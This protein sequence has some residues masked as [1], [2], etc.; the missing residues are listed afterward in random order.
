MASDNFSVLVKAELDP[1]S[2]SNLK[3][4]LTNALKKNPIPLQFE[5]DGLAV[6]VK[7]ET[8]KA[9]KDAKV[10][11][12][13]DTTGFM[14]EIKQDVAAIR[15]VFDNKKLS[16]KAD[17]KGIT[18]AKKEVL[19]LF[20]DVSKIESGKKL[21][22]L[23][24][25]VEDWDDKF[26]EVKENVK[27]LR[28]FVNDPIDVKVRL[29]TERFDTEVAE[30]KNKLNS[31]LTINVDGANTTVKIL[32]DMNIAANNVKATASGIGMVF[33]GVESEVKET[34][35]EV[36]NLNRAVD[37]IGKSGGIKSTNLGRISDHISAT[38]PGYTVLSG[39]GKTSAKSVAN[40]IPVS[41][42]PTFDQDDL[43][44]AVLRQNAEYASKHLADGDPF[45]RSPN[46]NHFFFKMA[47]GSQEGFTHPNSQTD[48]DGVSYGRL[49]DPTLEQK[50]Y[51][52]RHNG[53]TLED[54]FRQGKHLDKKELQR[55]AE[56]GGFQTLRIDYTPEFDGKGKFIR[57]K[58]PEEARGNYR[59]SERVTSRFVSNDEKID[60]AR[61][62]L[63]QKREAYNKGG[64]KTGRGKSHR[65][66]IEEAQRTL[67]DAVRWDDKTGGFV[68]NE[69]EWKAMRDSADKA[70]KDKMTKAWKTLTE[71]SHAEAL[72]QYRSAVLNTKSLINQPGRTPLQFER[73]AVHGDNATASG[74]SFYTQLQD[75]IAEETRRRSFGQLAERA[76]KSW[77][78]YTGGDKKADRDKSARAKFK[79][80]ESELG[81]LVRWDENVVRQITHDD[82]RVETLNGG[83]VIDEARYEEEE[84][85]RSGAD[86][87]R[88]TRARRTVEDVDLQNTR[89]RWERDE[90]KLSEAKKKFEADAVRYLNEEGIGAGKVKHRV[91]S[92]WTNAFYSQMVN[93]N[94]NTRGDSRRVSGTGIGGSYLPPGYWSQPDFA[95][96]YLTTTLEGNLRRDVNRDNRRIKQSQNR[97]AALQH[98][99]ENGINESGFIAPGMSEL[100]QFGL[101]EDDYAAFARGRVYGEG[102]ERDPQAVLRNI[103]SMIA[104]ENEKLYGR[105][106]TED[107]KSQ[108]ATAKQ[109]VKTLSEELR[110]ENIQ[111]LTPAQIEMK[112]QRYKAAQDVVTELEGRKVKG[113]I[114]EREERRSVANAE[115]ARM[116]AKFGIEGLDASI[117]WE[118]D[119]PIRGNADNIGLSPV[120]LQGI[121]M[122]DEDR[123]KVGSDIVQGIEYG[124]NYLGTE[125]PASR[126]SEEESRKL[127]AQVNAGEKARVL[128]NANSQLDVAQQNI[129][130]FRE[131]SLQSLDEFRIASSDIDDEVRRRAGLDELEAQRAEMQELRH[132]NREIRD[133][134]LS[135][136]DVKLNAN[137][138]I[139][140]SLTPEEGKEFNPENYPAYQEALQERDRLMAERQ[141]IEADYRKGDEYSAQQLKLNEA[142]QKGAVIIAQHELGRDIQSG[143]IDNAG[144]ERFVQEAREFESLSKALDVAR[145][146]VGQAW[147]EHQATLAEQKAVENRSYYDDHHVQYFADETRSRLASE[148]QSAFDQGFIDEG[149][150]NELNERLN[151]AYK[152]FE[153]KEAEIQVT[154]DTSQADAKL[155]ATEDKAEALDNKEVDI[156]VE[157]K[158]EVESG[159]KTEATSKPDGDAET[160]VKKTDARIDNALGKLGDAARFDEETGKYVIDKDKLKALQEGKSRGEKGAL[161]R[162]A[163]MVDPD[164]SWDEKK[165]KA[166]SKPDTSSTEQSTKAL[167]ENAEAS[168]KAAEAQEQGTKITEQSTTA[169][170]QNTKTTQENNETRENKLEPESKPKDKDG[171]K[172]SDT[173]KEPESKPTGKTKSKSKESDKPVELSDTAKDLIEQQKKINDI[174][175]QMTDRSL[176]TED[177][178]RLKSEL[179]ELTTGFNNA[180]SAANLTDDEMNAV[181]AAF[182][183]AQ[184]PVKQ[185]TDSFKKFL[186][187]AKK[188]GNYDLKGMKLDTEDDIKRAEQDINSL[189]QEYD[190]LRQSLNGQLSGNQLSQVVKEMDKVRAKI[191][192]INRAIDDA[193]N[194][195]VDVDVDKDV[196]VYKDKDRDKDF[197]VDKHEAGTVRKQVVD[198]IYQAQGR[199]DDI[200]WQM[201]NKNLDIEGF[202]K[203]S[204]ELHDAEVAYNE[205]IRVSGVTEAEMKE[206]AAAFKAVQAPTEQTTASF[207]KLVKVAKRIEDIKAIELDGEIVEP[208]Q[209]NKAKQELEELEHQYEQLRQSLRGQLSG[210]QLDALINEFDDTGKRV[211]K[212]RTINDNYES[213]KYEADYIVQ[214]S[215]AE[216]LRGKNVALDM[217]YDELKKTYQEFLAIMRSDEATI[218]EK[219]AAEER[220][221]KALKETGNAYRA[222]QALIKRDKS[223]QEI[224]KTYRAMEKVK[225]EAEVLKL[226]MAAWLRSNSAAVEDYGHKI[227]ELQ[228]RLK[229][230]GDAADLSNIR[231]EFKKV[232]LE[233]ELAGKA[234]AT[235][236]DRLKQQFTKYAA[237]FSVAELAMEAVQGLRYMYQAVLEVDTAMVGLRRVTDMTSQEY[238]QMFDNM[239][240]SSKEYGQTLTDTING[241]ADWVRAGFDTGTSLKLAEQTSVYQH[242]SDLDY[243]T[244]V[245]NQLTAYKGFESQLSDPSVFGKDVAGAVTYI[246]D[247]YNEIDNQFAVTSAGIGE[248]IQ[249][250]A[251]S[252][253]VAGNSLE[254]TVALVSAAM[255]TTQDPEGAGSSMKILSMRLRGM[256]GD[257]EALGEEVDDNVENI[258]KMQGQ[259]LNLTHG[260]VNIFDDAGEFRSTYD[261]MK[262]ISEVWDDLNSIEQADL[263]ET[264]AGK[265][266]ANTVAA[267]IENFAHAEQMYE[268][269]LDSSGSAAKENEKYLD[270]VQGRVDVLTASFQ[271]FST[272]AMNTEFLK[273]GI[274]ALTGVLDVITAI[275]D[276]LGLIPTVAALA[277]AALTFKKGAMPFAF[278]QDKG[279]MTLFGRTMSEYSTMA[280]NFSKGGLQGAVLPKAIKQWEGFEK[281]IT[282][283]TIAMKKFGDTYR[284]AGGNVGAA[285]RDAGVREAMKYADDAT[286]AYVKTPEFQDSLTNSVNQNQ[287]IA[288]QNHAMRVQEA[289]LLTQDKRFISAAKTIA[290]YRSGLEATNKVCKASG[291]HYQE[292][293]NIIA[294]NNPTLMNA[295][296]NSKTMGGAL[297]KYGAA[298]AGAA[299][300]TAVLT[301]ASMALNMALSMGIA[302][303]IGAVI[304]KIM[305]WIN[306]EKELAKEI[307]EVTASYKSQH[308][309]L[310]KG[311]G[312]FEEMA[313]RYAYLSKGVDRLSGANKTLTTAEYEEYQNIVNSLAEQVPTLV[314]GF[315][316]QGNAILSTVGD[317]NALTDAYNELII[318]E[319]DYLLNGDGDEYEGGKEIA[320]DFDNA[321]DDLQNPRAHWWNFFAR[322]N[323]IGA[324]NALDELW[325]IGH[326][327]AN[328]AKYIQ[329]V[330]FVEGNEL[331]R[332]RALGQ[333]LSNKMSS[334]NYELEDI[335]VPGVWYDNADAWVEY[336]SAVY[337]EYPDVVNEC[338]SDMEN[339]LDK[340]AEATHEMLGAF[341][342]NAF[343]RDEYDNLDTTAIQSVVTSIV[344]NLDS[345]LLAKI[346]EE[347]GGGEEGKNALLN[348]VDGIV[349]SLNDLDV[350]GLS[351]L[352]EAF[353]LADQYALGEIDSG[354]YLKAMEDFQDVMDGLGLDR[355]VQLAINA[356]LGFDEEGFKNDYDNFVSELETKGMGTELAQKLV[357]DLN[358][359]EFQI[360]FD[361]VM[362]GDIDED[363]IKEFQ[364]AYQKALDKGVDFDKTVYGNVDLNDRQVLHWNDDTLEQNKT[365]LMSHSYIKGQGDFDKQW[366]ETK[367]K[368]MEQ[369][370]SAVDAKFNVQNGIPIAYTP[371]LQTEHGPEYID[372][373]TMN[374]YTQELYEGATKDGKFDKEKFIELDAKGIIVDGKK[375]NNMI[376][377]IGDTAYDT[378]QAMQYVGE[379]GL[380]IKDTELGREVVQRIKV[381]AALNYS[382]DMTSDLDSIE[383]VNTAISDMNA[384][385]GLTAE[386]MA[387]LEARFGGLESYNPSALFEKTADGI[388]VNKHELDKLNAELNDTNM[389]DVQ[390]HIDT[391]TTAYNELTAEID[392]CDNASQRA[393]MMAERDTYAR[394]IENLQLYQAQLV[395][396]T[397]AY[398]KWQDA[399]NTGNSRDEYENIA[400]GRETIEE[401]MGRGWFGED[402]MAYIDMFAYEDMAANGA[403]FDDYVAMYK[404][405]GKEIG[406][407]GFS[408][409]DFFTLDEDGNATSKGV[410]N[411]FEAVQ[412][413]FGKGYAWIDEE[414]GKRMFDFG[415]GKME[416]IAKEWGMGT[417]SIQAILEAALEAGYE[418]DWESL[419]NIEDF[420]TSSFEEVVAAAE[421]A[422]TSLNKIFPDK[423][424][425]FNFDAGDISTATQEVQDAQEAYKELITDENG[426]IN[427]QAE[428]A[429]EMRLILSTLLIQKQQLEQPSIMNIS[430]TGDGQIDTAIG[431]IQDFQTKYNNFEIAV[432]TGVDVGKTQQELNDVLTSLTEDDFKVMAD[433]GIG[434]NSIEEVKASVQSAIKQAGGAEVEIGTNLQEGAIGQLQNT[435]QTQCTPDVIAEVTGYEVSEEAEGTIATE[436][437]V[438]W[439]NA[440]DPSKQKFNA[441][442]TVNWNKHDINNEPTFSATGQ[443]TWK[444]TNVNIKVTKLANGTAHVNGT[445][446]ANG[447]V[448]DAFK[449]GNWGVKKDTPALT[450]E[451]GQELVVYKDRYWTVGDNGAEFT[452]IPKGAIVFNHK[453]TEELFKNGKVTSDGGRAKALH[454][455]TAF[456]NGTMPKRGTAF[457]ENGD[458][459]GSGPEDP[460]ETITGLVDNKKKKKKKNNGG[461][462]GNNG[463]SGGNGNNN[464]DFKEKFDWIEI[465][466]DRIERAISNLGVT[467]DSVYESWEKRNSALG[468]SIAK[469][470]EEI[471]IQRRGQLRYLKEANKVKLSEA[472]KKKVREGKIDIETITDEKLAERI[473]EYQEW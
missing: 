91:N 209:I 78:A 117:D 378:Y 43:N 282:K 175:S 379:H 134:R 3:T 396:T 269:A 172:E 281:Q 1:S 118:R 81:N 63:D 143:N 126:I 346:N 342:E 132:Q 397:N 159:V 375:I 23:D 10:K 55:L 266:R 335:D 313:N 161:T 421:A 280:G 386:G 144:I 321:Y 102:A 18:Q 146:N 142:R 471:N 80:A 177:Y 82:G 233:A 31:G 314:K 454:G 268:T 52:I 448:G 395:G 247:M 140:E 417:E 240:A 358:A 238:N 129:D 323:S 170:E 97:I 103:D 231:N 278:N 271:A 416:Q 227:K 26:N 381:Q 41:K 315:D 427:L 419:Y 219:V 83:Y 428:G 277:G 71:S 420:D 300:K 283:N 252:M 410:G 355:D 51:E 430:L 121:E 332:A 30:L 207:R 192:A 330:D 211:K 214:S 16:F 399:Q 230:C 201:T 17:T 61:S 234:T 39:D 451:L 364:D 442:G 372:E 432:A 145:E 131:R 457:L 164:F 47:H 148:I 461:T 289:S 317:V 244:A 363:S 347:A 50:E 157:T 387:D 257:L 353:T 203:L 274:G 258:S 101:T 272:T 162:Y 183:S 328:V 326:D 276:Q 181:N 40:M 262:D 94:T 85:R 53:M 249:R 297:I 290:D 394:Q 163:K 400:K 304:T 237:Y 301:A 380:L 75:K 197:D 426:K 453:Q 14:S 49:Y 391:L 390:E 198:D 107:E 371:I 263:L 352:E 38:A 153:N 407:T 204:K 302:M 392:K 422:T 72:K 385:A 343:L 398:K 228:E 206:V 403:T 19:E 93:L 166:E 337:N 322:E 292:L 151:S 169:T 86:K 405:M 193:R 168:K 136:N 273:G 185:T 160:G 6:K 312:D 215:N 465:K 223:A 366:Q 25:R 105:D 187:T 340:E 11:V 95:R 414:T 466:I 133:E 296:N 470:T 236:G 191:E 333:A 54:F 229:N 334:M 44:R 373:D 9:S 13:A 248:A 217:S 291:L 171:D 212:F 367:K 70:G 360:L 393:S 446:F 111:G 62:D 440:N 21:L 469:T 306:A 351:A 384:S 434:G 354:E 369:E 67:G 338:I 308:D 412:K 89:A 76:D 32:G 96:Q 376:A 246:T 4:E 467:S 124:L 389:S 305:D 150:F 241:T 441:D 415:D 319:N 106:L 58:A 218:A 195:P 114:P 256:K 15:A 178:E 320:T 438:T 33:D 186:D 34:T 311:K 447:T 382:Y 254:Q 452:T 473:K 69:A 165:L 472:Y 224:E 45:T 270:S 155:E 48:M 110:M 316:A 411:F 154:A 284:K 210:N 128:A 90:R 299:A 253:N 325:T 190:E 149:K 120:Q 243:D 298:C 344:D 324:A 359:G 406:N 350:G 22:Q 255:E 365:A 42:N 349:S 242:I 156:E 443:V 468:Q 147:G 108:L 370:Y 310:I 73:I 119:M 37:A 423:N 431:K 303:A 239:I 99:R 66:W 463:G 65:Q 339:E 179:H 68:K 59:T 318:A 213:G 275:I 418:V 176:S 5:V 98:I 56:K 409:N 137:Q 225:G 295:I 341:L 226:S 402:T 127:D 125:L 158:P 265:H 112:E 216:K 285:W 92:N 264:I 279:T 122:S 436:G 115:L 245:E 12:D 28:S 57:M 377:D 464:K 261:I 307:D 113:L 444:G 458:P 424:Y 135:A 100:K 449:Q 388:R 74:K 7:A 250:S 437:T 336:I 27:T 200:K 232:K 220:L 404:K 374:K 348:Y 29:D 455:G 286:R 450:G 345:E 293:G 362:S 435:I 439:K 456:V 8:K 167:E 294:K 20:N 309:E 425:S 202:N 356:S 445:A 60:E 429:E 267:L 413:E 130:S 235:F 194:R 401:E 189:E 88:L 123:K 109:R 331:E 259:V 357:A 79:K 180:K 208:G 287:A 459:Y 221:Q 87:A 462:T 368:F 184:A 173:E 138:A 24:V 460:F 222:T 139:I 383:K 408:M 84:K 327:E 77:R 116:K 2:T 182:E 199:I 36:E 35:Q 329:Q 141:K 251:S 196:D 174:K 46:Q 104:A 205:I 260:Q 433:L 152:P 188:L 64:G 361:A 288:N